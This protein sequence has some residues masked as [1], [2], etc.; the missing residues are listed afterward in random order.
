MFDLGLVVET[1]DP[2]S[3]KTVLSVQEGFNV[4]YITVDPIRAQSGTIRISGGSVSGT[5]ELKALGN[6]TVTIKNDSPAYLR[7]KGIEIPDNDGGT[8]R[9]NGEAVTKITGFGGKINAS[10][11]GGKPTIT[12]MNTFAE[13]DVFA[14]NDQ[15][16]WS[17]FRTPDL[18]IAGEI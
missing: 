18:E 4:P 3:G 13:G 5:G 15:Y 17:L 14:G 9:L 2:I 12:V 7:L 10:A 1:V 16:P 6:V 8:V 11:D